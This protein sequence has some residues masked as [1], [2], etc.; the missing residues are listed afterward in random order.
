MQYALAT[1][2]GDEL[3]GKSPHFDMGISESHL[4]AGIERDFMATPERTDPDKKARLSAVEVHAPSAE[5]HEGNHSRN[6]RK[7]MIR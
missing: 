2:H 3:P 6:E 5:E 7:Q 4:R 1:G